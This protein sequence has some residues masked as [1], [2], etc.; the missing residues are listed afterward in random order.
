[1]KKASEYHQ[2]AKECRDLASRA[3]DKE[4][5]KTLLKMAD[6]WEGLGNEREVYLAQKLRLQDLIS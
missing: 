5:R 4:H 3:T 1:M 2:H 6:T